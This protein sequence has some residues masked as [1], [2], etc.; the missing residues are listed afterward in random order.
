MQQEEAVRG[1]WRVWVLDDEG[2]AELLPERHET[3]EKAVLA[4]VDAA[5]ERGADTTG[6]SEGDGPLV[7]YGVDCPG[8]TRG[9]CEYVPE[10]YDPLEDEP[11]LSVEVVFVPDG[12]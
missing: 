7:D 2:G 9:C 1:H 11:F 10:G 12:E 5:E 6:H 8:D 3:A 4:G